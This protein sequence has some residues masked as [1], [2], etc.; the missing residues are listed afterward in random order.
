MT[1]HSITY[2]SMT[3]YHSRVRQ[4][5][6]RHNVS[7]LYMT[8]HGRA[9]APQRNIAYHSIRN[10]CTWCVTA[11]PCPGIMAPSRDRTELEQN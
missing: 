7:H 11:S 5:T 4:K 9:S 6:S 1:D 8:E 2:Q 10:S 3:A